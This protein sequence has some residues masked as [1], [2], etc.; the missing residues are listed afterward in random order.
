MWLIAILFALTG[1]VRGSLLGGQVENL[2]KAASDRQDDVATSDID[3]DLD[4]PDGA[5]LIKLH[6]TFMVIAWLG[7]TSMGILIARYFKRT[8]VNRQIFGTEAWFFWHRA[9]MLF[10]WTFTLIAF[11]MIFIDVDG[12]SYGEA[13]HAILGTITTILCFFHPILAMFRP[14][15]GDDKRK[16]FNWGHRFGGVLAHLLATVTIFL[17]IMV[18]KA[19]L[20]NWLYAILSLAVLA[21]VTAHIY[22]TVLLRK[23]QQH[24]SYSNRNIDAPYSTWRKRGLLIFGLVSLC[25]V[26]AIVTI[27]IL[28][29]IGNGSTPEAPDETAPAMEND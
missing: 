21:Y 18:K 14:S 6:G 7:T 23:A 11:I 15:L 8:W 1:A 3:I 16:Y 26:A 27:I 10:T 24:G 4:L 2:P 9:C 29:P 25:L 5:T 20:P 12:W 13:P 17:S 28:A 22:F 19:Q